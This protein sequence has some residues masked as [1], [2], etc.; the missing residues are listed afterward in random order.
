MD[1]VSIKGSRSLYVYLLDYGWPEGEWEQIFKKH[2]MSMADRA[3]AVQ[4][5][6]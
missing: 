5:S 3:R 1:T 2:F 6:C 4:F